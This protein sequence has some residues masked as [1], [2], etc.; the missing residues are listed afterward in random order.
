M[1]AICGKVTTIIGIQEILFSQR[2]IKLKIYISIVL[3][4]N[5]RRIVLIDFYS[6]DYFAIPSSF[7]TINILAICKLKNKSTQCYQSFTIHQKNFRVKFAKN[8]ICEN[9]PT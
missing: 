9:K 7:S 1:T 4:E 2:S 3:M 5:Q 6:I 8:F